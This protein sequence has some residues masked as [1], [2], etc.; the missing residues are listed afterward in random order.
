MCPHGV[1]K[2]RTRIPRVSKE[3]RGP[4]AVHVSVLIFGPVQRFARC[5]VVDLRRVCVCV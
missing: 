1:A 5:V 4:A 2:T 3:N